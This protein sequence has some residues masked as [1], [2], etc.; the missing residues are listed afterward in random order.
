MNKIPLSVVVITKNEE[1][2]IARCLKSASFADELAPVRLARQVG[3]LE[4]ERCS[5][6]AQT[7]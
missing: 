2:N 1:H 6:L 5:R 3:E 4:G 7:C